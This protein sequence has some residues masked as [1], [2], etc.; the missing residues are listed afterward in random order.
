M[1]R[2]EAHSK[3]RG[4]PPVQQQHDEECKSRADELHDRELFTQPDET[5]LGECPLCFLPLPIDPLKF[6]FKPCCSR[7]IC[8]GCLYAY[9]KSG[10]NFISNIN[11]LLKAFSCPFCREPVSSGDEETHK[12]NMKRIKA[13]DPAAMNYMGEKCYRE[14]DNEGAL[15]WFTKAAELGNIDAHYN[16]GVMY[17]KGIGVEKDMEKA[18]YH[19]EKAAIGG[20]PHA[21]HNLA[22]YEGRNGN[23]ERAVKHWIIAAN[24]GYEVSMQALWLK[25]KDGNIT[26]EDLE[27]TLRTHQAAIDA[28]KSEQRDAAAEVVLRK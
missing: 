10:G 15:E 27:V 26:K 2:K 17:E 1:S 16:I 25:F 3:P 23:M 18:V 21:R 9:T 28:T 4:E 8:S 7:I 22:C 6:W 24:L 5:H 13:N 20:S 14:G 11:E 12:R 19:Y